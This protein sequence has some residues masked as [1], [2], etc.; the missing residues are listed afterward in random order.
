MTGGRAVLALTVFG[1][2]SMIAAVK[3]WNTEPLTA[4]F[5]LTRCHKGETRC[6]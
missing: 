6:R 4:A 3:P 5:S 2:T 1:R